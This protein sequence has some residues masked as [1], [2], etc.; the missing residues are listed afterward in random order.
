MAH[1]LPGARAPTHEFSINVE[2]SRVSNG[3]KRN[4]RREKQKTKNKNKAKNEIDLDEIRR[5]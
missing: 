1:A 2:S 5:Q 4:D 3:M